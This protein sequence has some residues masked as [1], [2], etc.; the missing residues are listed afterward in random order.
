M[1]CTSLGGTLDPECG[2]APDLYGGKCHQEAGITFVGAHLL[3][4]GDILQ[5][6]TEEDCFADLGHVCVGGS[7]VLVT[8]G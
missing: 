2:S 7:M 3:K 8:H 6:S 4:A 1:L 5:C